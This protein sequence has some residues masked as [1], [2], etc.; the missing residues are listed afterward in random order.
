[1]KADK[2]NEAMLELAEVINIAH[3]GR[4]GTTQ[5][6]VAGS[7]RHVRAI[8]NKYF[9]QK[10]RERDTPAALELKRVAL[11]EK[12]EAYYDPAKVPDGLPALRCFLGDLTQLEGVLYIMYWAY[13][14][15]V[16]FNSR[17]SVPS[18]YVSAAFFI[19]SFIKAYAQR[20]FDLRELGFKID[21]ERCPEK[22]YDHY[23]LM[24]W[25]YPTQRALEV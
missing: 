25:E 2:I 13:R 15:S 20:V 22:P 21:S 24:A 16:L 18:G 7:V 9:R 5:V 3:A 8:L 23:R 1:M 14:G 10:Y 6:T 19:E 11:M 12:I 17:A 4:A